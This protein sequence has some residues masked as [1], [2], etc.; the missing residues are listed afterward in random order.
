MTTTPRCDSQDPQLPQA[1]LSLAK[2]ITALPA[3]EYVIRL[4]RGEKGRLVWQIL[5]PYGEPETY[6][7]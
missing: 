6:E 2:R 7:N 5:R 4:T 3:G 1:A